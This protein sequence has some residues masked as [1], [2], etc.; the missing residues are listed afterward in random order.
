MLLRTRV[1]FGETVEIS[2]GDA[3]GSGLRSKVLVCDDDKGTEGVENGD[4]NGRLAESNNAAN[5]K[6]I[7][8][9]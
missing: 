7:V 9:W 1:V 8:D 3:N 4:A 6:F 5:L 2:V